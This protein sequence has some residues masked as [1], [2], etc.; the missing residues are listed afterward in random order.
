MMKNRCMLKKRTILILLVLLSVSLSWGK[1]EEPYQPAYKDSRLSPVQRVA[2]LL[3]RMTLEEKVGQMLCL[4]GWNNHARSGDKMR[5]TDEFYTDIDSL[6]C[7]MFW[8]V[9]RADPWTQ[10][11]LVTGLNP[12]LAAETANAMQRYAIEHTRLGI[13]LFFA[14]EAPHGHMAIGTTVFP[15]GIGMSATFDTCLMAKV[16][17]AIAKEIRLQGGHI[18]YGPVLDLV[19][20]PR[21]SRVEETMGEDPVLTGEMGAALIRGMGGG[22]LE[23]PDATLVTPKHLIAYG[24]SEGGL[25]GSPTS[26]G[27]RA[28]H[29]FFLPPFRKAVEAGALSVMT[30]YNSVDG[31]PCTSNPYLLRDVLYGQWGFRGFVVS[32]LYSIN[33]LSSD[34]HVAGTWEEAAMLAAGAG[35]HV[36]LGGL[37][38]AQL[39]KAVREGR[40]EERLVDEA[41]SRVLMAKFEMGLFDHPYVTPKAAEKGVRTADHLALARQVAQESITL[42]K[43]QNHILPLSRNIRVAVVGPNADSRYNLL[44][45]YTAPQSDDQV[46]TVLEGIRDKLSASQVE[47]VRG[48]AIRDTTLN[49]IAQATAAARRADVVVAVVGGSSARD[50]RTSYEKTGAASETN[51]VSDMECGEGFDRASLSLMGRQEQLLHALRQTG[52]PLV[53]VY[54]EGRPLDKTWAADEADALLTAYYPG[55]QGGTAIADVLFGDCNPAGRLSV[56]VPRGVGQLPVYY[57]RLRSA[58]HEYI[59]MS[60]KPLFAF[61]YGLSYTKFEYSNLNVRDAGEGR[62]EVSFDVANVGG[63]DGD[64]VSQLYLSDEVA[65]VVMPVMQLRHFCRI[66]LKAGER[67]R[68]SFMVGDED[69]EVVTPDLRH[70]AEPGIFEVMVGAASDDIRLRGKIVFQLSQVE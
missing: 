66:H 54:V 11:T 64:E 26:I 48:C 21:W 43:N 10:K 32:D 22:R 42:L 69:F 1:E 34:H 61:G 45:D 28:L 27:T 57:N 37:A 13:P 25:N 40:V 36:D 55:Q 14:E 63:M 23:R 17:K 68:V 29:T 16:G 24:A 59:D 15:T 44:G 9:F 62:F 70:V 65:S 5:L 53:V 47:Y 19:R 20:D 30:S 3:P 31:V 2:D 50:F 35:V 60:T 18:S 52:K 41:A 33:T 51:T 8:G 49:E 6:H 7:G 46:V 56:S 67:R 58:T 12:R 4:L 38:F 39:V